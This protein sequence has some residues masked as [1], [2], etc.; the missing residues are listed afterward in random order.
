MAWNTTVESIEKYIEKS[1]YPLNMYNYR[2]ILILRELEKYWYVYRE[3]TR[4]MIVGV[5]KKVE[6]QGDIILKR[7]VEPDRF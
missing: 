5:L 1:D 2:I 6:R 3:G 7:E 4:K